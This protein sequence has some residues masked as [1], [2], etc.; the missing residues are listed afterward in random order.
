MKEQI[1]EN[2][3]NIILHAGDARVVCKK[4]LDLLAEGRIEEAKEEMKGADLEIA[5]AHHIQTDCIQGA[6]AGEEFEYNVLFAHAQDTLMTIYSEITLAKQLIRIS[7]H[8]EARIDA[9]E[10]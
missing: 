2:A 10:K 4:A 3:M 9:L 8:L 6:I 5:E 7:E 1:I